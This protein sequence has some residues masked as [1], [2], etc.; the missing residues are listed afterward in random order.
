M[1]LH[2][3]LVGNGVFIDAF[4]F[5]ISFGSALVPQIFP[6]H[7]D[8]VSDMQGGEVDSMILLAQM[9][10]SGYGCTRDTPQAE[11]W[12]KTARAIRQE[13]ERYANSD[14]M[15]SEQKSWSKR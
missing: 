12:L 13:D 8:T 3:F 15:F 14:K 11:D 4:P 5:R 6:V 10:L 1:R 7:T 9:L 2:S